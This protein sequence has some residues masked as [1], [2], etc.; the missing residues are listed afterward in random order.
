MYFS[1]PLCIDYHIDA[2]TKKIHGTQCI[3]SP[4]E[5]TRKRSLYHNYGTATPNSED[6]HPLQAT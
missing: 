6:C 4:K 3:F 1:L 5:N 2:Q